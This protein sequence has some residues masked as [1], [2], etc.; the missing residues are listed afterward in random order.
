[1]SSWVLDI[2]STVINSHL[3]I[4]LGL[5]EVLGKEYNYALSNL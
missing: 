3:E 1:M 5:Q 2:L 4:D